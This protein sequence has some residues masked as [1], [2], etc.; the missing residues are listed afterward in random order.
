LYKPDWEEA[1]QRFR[2]WWAGEA[3]DRC[4]LIVTAPKDGVSS[5]EPPKA[6]SDPIQRWSDLDYLARLNDYVHRH[7]FYGG[8]AFPVWTAGQPGHTN[9]AT[10]CG[11]PVTLDMQTGW[12]EPIL[13]GVEWTLNDIRLDKQHRWYR[14][15]IEMLQ[16]ATE[17]SRGKAVVSVGAFGGCGDT[18]AALRGSERL[19]MDVVERPELARQTEL[20]LMEMWIELYEEFYAI[21]SSAGQGVTCAYPLWSEGRYYFTQCDFSGMISTEMFAKLFLPAI[22]RQLEYLDC[23]VH[24]LDGVDAFRHVGLLC[25]L[26]RLRAIQVLPGAGKPSAAHY[27]DVLKEVQSHG[28]SLHLRI[29]PEDVELAL[30]ELS[31]RGVLIQTSCKTEQEARSLL[32]D[33]RK[34]SHD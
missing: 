16:R 21:V 13:T 29:P 28:K 8:E 32:T 19:S 2:A 23:A 30:R 27:M 7:T 18:L 22:E 33:V 25:E 1:K 15:Q 3:M 10:W 9:V 31:A 6:P 5:E 4:A 26:P 20:Y 11:C 17:L 12:H 14:F 34:W 24:H